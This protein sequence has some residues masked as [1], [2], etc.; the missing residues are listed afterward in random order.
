MAMAPVYTVLGVQL[1]PRQYFVLAQPL[2][3]EHKSVTSCAPK[4]VP[5]GGDALVVG[6]VVSS[7]I[8]ALTG[9]AG[10]PSASVAVA[11]IVFVP[12]VMNERSVCHV[13]IVG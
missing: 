4:N 10:F 7:R 13:V 9:L 8:T 1:E 11:V 6:A 2:L 12:S 3:S 5:P